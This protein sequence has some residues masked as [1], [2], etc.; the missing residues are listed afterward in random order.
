MSAAEL[1]ATDGWLQPSA[2]AS[3]V[4]EVLR[5]EGKLYA[6]LAD[7]SRWKLVE[8]TA[9]GYLQTITFRAQPA[10][11]VRSPGT[12]QTLKPEL[13]LPQLSKRCLRWLCSVASEPARITLGG[14]LFATEQPTDI[15]QGRRLVL[16]FK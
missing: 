7:S 14:E 5:N 12:R 9:S 2:V 16:F 11:P 15:K 10:D 8:E 3:A 4:S 1:V 13:L 6:E